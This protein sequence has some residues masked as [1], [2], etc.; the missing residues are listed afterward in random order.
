MSNGK[1]TAPGRPIG[2]Q[3]LR[4]RAAKLADTAL[5][6]LA[7]VASDQ[8]TEPTARI[9]AA[10]V[11]LQEARGDARPLLAATQENSNE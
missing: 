6:A 2:A 10:R 7:N 3:G 8:N 1:I 5:A 11:I 4:S 9:E